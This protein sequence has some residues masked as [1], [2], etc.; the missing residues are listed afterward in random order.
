MGKRHSFEKGMHCWTNQQWYS[1]AFSWSRVRRR[2]MRIPAKA[3]TQEASLLA[4]AESSWMPVYTG[5]TK[6]DPLQL[7]VTD[8]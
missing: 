5:M 7:H 3:G 6:I 4:S 8:Y 2:G 1:L